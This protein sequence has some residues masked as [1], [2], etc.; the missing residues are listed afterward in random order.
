[1]WTCDLMDHLMVELDTIVA[2]VSLTYSAKT[3]LFKLH[4]MDEQVL[5]DFF[6]DK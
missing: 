2:L 6:D 4:P 5:N 3:N 1:M